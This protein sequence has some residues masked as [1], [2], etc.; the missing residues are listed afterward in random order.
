M[1]SE[2]VGKATEKMKCGRAPGPFGVA[3]ELLKTSFAFTFLFCATLQM[4]SSPSTKFLI[5]MSFIINLFKGKG[6]ALDR[7]SYRGLKTA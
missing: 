4:L 1:R 3:T 7:G 6:D 2:L 5:E